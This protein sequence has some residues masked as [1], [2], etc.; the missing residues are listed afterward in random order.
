L[1]G[2]H[3]K[4]G[5]NSS[6]AFDEVEEISATVASLFPAWSHAAVDAW[7]PPATFANAAPIGVVEGLVAT[8]AGATPQAPR[9]LLPRQSFEIPLLLRIPD[10]AS[11]I[12][13]T[14]GTGRAAA[15]ATLNDSVD[16]L[17]GS[18]P[19][20]RVSFTFLDPVGLGES[21]SGM[22]RLADYEESLISSKIWTQPDQIERRLVE[23]NEH[24]EKVIQM[25]LRNEFRTITEYND[26]AGNIAESTASW[27]S[28][29]FRTGFPRPPCS[30]SF[31]SPRRVRDAAFTSCFTGTGANPIPSGS[32][33][34][35]S[36][37]MRLRSSLPAMVSPYSN[38]PDGVTVHLE[39]PPAPNRPEP[40]SIA[41]AR[42]ASIPPGWKFIR[43][44][45]P[46]RFRRLERK[47]DQ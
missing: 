5:S 9:L 15:L 7:T 23:L 35:I 42:P 8:L 11:L 28:R 3:R 41:S 1:G 43:P 22:M 30:A 33:R 12:I 20:G 39:A 32:R 29:I 25:Y 16:R 13:E 34:K 38:Q 44:H 36:G 40:F 19:P 46:G 18:V 37:P 47:H 24:M 26:Q 21:F 6:G 4:F 10:Q 2:A 31:P 45:R 17:L 27:S 14:R